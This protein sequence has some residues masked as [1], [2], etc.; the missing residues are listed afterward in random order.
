MVNEYWLNSLLSGWTTH[1]INL[2][3]NAVVSAV[4]ILEVAGGAAIATLKNPSEGAR[5]LLLAKRQAVGIIKYSRISAKVAGQTLRHGRNILDEEGMVNEA[6]NNIVGDVAIGSGNVDIT[7][8]FSDPNLSTMDR[9]GNIIRLPSRGLMGGDELFK[10][11]NFR[12]KAY[13]YAAEEVDKMI[14][15]GKIKAKDFDANVEKRLDDGADRFKKSE[16]MLW[17]MYPLIIG[18]F[19]IEKGIL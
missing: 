4:D 13:A 7:K 11:L 15:A 2:T 18:L 6:V 10:Q 5:Q 1:A 8:I 9:I 17:G 14:G 12:A 3:S 16:L 19:L